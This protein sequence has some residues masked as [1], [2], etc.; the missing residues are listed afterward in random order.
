M[1]HSDSVGDRVW[2][3][4]TGG[5]SVCMTYLLLTSPLFKIGVLKVTESTFRYIHVIH[6]H[7]ILF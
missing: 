1:H 3:I 4:K 6:C 2:A 5:G 7:D